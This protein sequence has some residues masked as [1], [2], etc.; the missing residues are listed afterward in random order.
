MLRQALS[1]LKE[2][3]GRLRQVA[4]EWLLEMVKNDRLDFSLWLR[5]QRSFMNAL[6]R[7]IKDQ[8]AHMA[9][10]AATYQTQGFSAMRDGLLSLLTTL[11]P[12]DVV[13][14]DA[15]VKHAL[16]FREMPLSLVAPDRELQRI[17]QEAVCCSRHDSEMASG[18]AWVSLGIWREYG[19]T[20]LGL[21]EAEPVTITVGKGKMAP[22]FLRFLKDQVDADLDPG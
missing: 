3:D 18:L 2:L 19:I 13:K 17:A 11:Y 21:T 6:H 8:Y 5:W 16:D 15:P 12:A 4:D 1:L 22:E 14:T 9:K 20:T 7:V 10:L